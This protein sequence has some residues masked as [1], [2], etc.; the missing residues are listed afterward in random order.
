MADLKLNL[1]KREKVK[2]TGFP[3]GTSK[4]MV[5]G[6][7]DGGVNAVN[8]MVNKGLVGAKLV[9]VDTDTQ[10]LDMSKADEVIQIGKD[11]TKGRGTG[12]DVQKG[13]EAAEDESR[14]FEEILSGVNLV[15]ITAGMGG[16]TGTGSSPVMARLAQEE[17]I[18]T[19]GIVTKPFE[20]EG[21]IRRD[22]AKR[23]I[24][25]LRSCVD[26]L[27]IISNDKLLENAPPNLSM[28]K[29]F[30]MAD[31]I[32]HQGVGGVSELITVPGLINLDFVDIENVMRGAGTCHLGF[33][34]GQGTGKV[35]QAAQA[36]TTNPL[37]EGGS[38]Q[39]ARRML[40]NITGGQ[41]LKLGEVNEAAVRIQELASSEGEVVFGTVI[42]EDLKDRAEVTVI[43]GDFP[44]KIEEEEPIT[45]I[46]KKEPEI[47]GNQEENLDI[48]AFLRRGRK[49]KDDKN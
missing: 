20:F 15:F 22:R 8:R 38:I 41:D 30:E 11:L 31:E 28:A 46:K 17:G 16:G 3:S 44:E 4:L 18:L 29:S 2:R 39:G 24:D 32:L 19:I 13:R 5:I 35:N 21:K 42:K 43:A 25:T 23:G 6:V 34:T 10:V 12:G 9:A 36:A 27:I 40:I 45:T 47:E 37:V 48:P 33:G 1:S 49:N 7:G 14:R 26:A